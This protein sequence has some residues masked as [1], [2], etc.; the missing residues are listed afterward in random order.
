LLDVE[1]PPSGGALLFRASLGS[2]C[3]GYAGWVEAVAYP[4]FADDVAGAVGLFDLFAK[5][6]DEDAEVF[7]LAVAGWAPDGA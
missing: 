1:A 6:G 7:G 3:F 5:L 4:G 2:G